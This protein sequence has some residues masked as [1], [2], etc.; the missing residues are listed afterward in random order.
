MREGGLARR[1]MSDDPV[2][3]VNKA[4][5]LLN[6]S[7]YE[8]AITTL[9]TLKYW[10]PTAQIYLASAY[11]GL[12]QHDKAKGLLAQFTADTEIPLENLVEAAMCSLRLGDFQHAIPI[13]EKT[14]ASVR[15]EVGAGFA[16]AAY[17]LADQKP[18]E[19]LRVIQ[20]I[21]EA[22]PDSIMAKKY[23]NELEISAK[24]M[25]NEEIQFTKDAMIPKHFL[26][27]VLWR[28]QQI[29]DSCNELQETLPIFVIGDSHVQIFSGTLVQLPQL[30]EPMPRLLPWFAPIHIGPILAWGF[31]K[32]DRRTRGYERLNWLITE[33]IIPPGSRIMLS[34]GEIDIRVHVREQIER[35]QV[36]KFQVIDQIVS[37]LIT[38]GCDL[39]DKGFK[40]MFWAPIGAGKPMDFG[41]SM[42]DPNGD[43]ILRNEYTRIFVERMR[44]LAEPLGMPV[45]AIFD[46]MVDEENKSDLRLLCDG[47]HLGLWSLPVIQTVFRKRFGVTPE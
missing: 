16:L 43:M 21:R 25:L 13:L 10:F 33:K 26:S 6:L 14:L 15:P 17:F 35:Q 29:F 38:V 2:V 12:F 30:L 23:S 40:V 28:W 36:S 37:S 41:N 11:T 44:E 39:L 22:F 31:G 24:L 34:A 8:E 5:D 46:E 7:R 45:L 27:T 1:A 42:P 20:Q 32:A 4:I 47:L 18:E 9:E 19:A 3:I